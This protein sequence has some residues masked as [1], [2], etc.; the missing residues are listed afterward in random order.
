MKDSTQT[1]DGQTPFRIPVQRQSDLIPCKT[2]RSGFPVVQDILHPQY[3]TTYITK[4]HHTSDAY[5]QTQLRNWSVL[6]NSKRKQR[7]WQ[8]RPFPKAITWD[9]AET[10]EF[11]QMFDPAFN[12]LMGLLGVVKHRG[13][14]GEDRNTSVWPRKEG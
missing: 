3:A 14:P 4:H 11:H 9:Q 7:A 13:Y 12:L 5:H 6:R 8:K 2:R 1:V 10:L